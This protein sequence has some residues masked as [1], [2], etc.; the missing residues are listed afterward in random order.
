MFIKFIF[1]VIL[2]L[3]VLMVVLVARIIQVRH[4]VKKVELN[5][6]KIKRSK[7]KDKR[8]SYSWY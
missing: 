3:M 2:G 4:E 1:G 6:G 7:K 5:C 8:H